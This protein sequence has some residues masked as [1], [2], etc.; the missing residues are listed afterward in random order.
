MRSFVMEKKIFLKSRTFGRS[1][2]GIQYAVLKCTYRFSFGY[3]KNRNTYLGE[4]LLDIKCVVHLSLQG[5]LNSSCSDKYFASY[6]RDTQMNAC[7]SSCKV[8]V[9]FVRSSQRLECVYKFY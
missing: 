9:I 1:V 4:N 2:D 8:P 7:R 6:V 3:L 5:M